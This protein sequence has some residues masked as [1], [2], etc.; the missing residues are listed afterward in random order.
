MKK[1]L[2]LQL[3]LVLFLIP[4][5]AQKVEKNKDSSDSILLN[6]RKPSVF[7]SYERYGERTPAR[8]DES[9]KGVWLKLHN[10]SKW[11][12]Y[13]KTYGADNEKNEYRVS[14]EVRIIPGLE[15]EKRESKLP[16]GYRINSNSTI[17]AIEP[18]KSI[19]FSVPQ[20]NLAEGLAV[21]VYF[22]YEWEILGKFGGDL[23]ILH[24]ASFWSTDLPVK[25]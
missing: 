15:W 2:Y 12:I 24:Q 6:P 10:N 21:F 14:Y 5:S 19:I 18:G 9:N 3:Y 16:I 17:R 11:K 20:E 1:I 4:V 7:I 8:Q 22:S 25:K 23:S 13:L